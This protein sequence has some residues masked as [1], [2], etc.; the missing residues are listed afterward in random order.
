MMILIQQIHS[1]INYKWHIQHLLSFK[2]TSRKVFTLPTY[3]QI[4][5][6]FIHDHKWNTIRIYHWS[7]QNII[8]FSPNH[9]FSHD[10]ID[11]YNNSYFIQY[12]IYCKYWLLNRKTPHTR[13]QSFLIISPQLHHYI[14]SEIS[15]CGLRCL[16][17]F[18]YQIN[19]QSSH[20]NLISK[21]HKQSQNYL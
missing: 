13:Q 1:W 10:I 4:H 15:E 3:H 7:Y 20:D 18:Q 12:W 8:S 5:R 21:D 9:L 16:I 6:R 2:T 19:Y 17:Q 14:F 11:I